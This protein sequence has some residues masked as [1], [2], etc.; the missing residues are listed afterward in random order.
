MPENSPLEMPPINTSPLVVQMITSINERL[1]ALSDRVARAEGRDS[2]ERAQAQVLPKLD[3]ARVRV[4]IQEEIARALADQGKLDI[5][6]ST[7]I[8]DLKKRMGLVQMGIT[9]LITLAGTAGPSVVAWLKKLM[10]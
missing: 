1:N 3:E 5:A 2:G 4:I 7:E 10:G 9:S 8:Q 6:Q